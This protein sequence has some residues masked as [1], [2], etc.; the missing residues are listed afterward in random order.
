M[1]GPAQ[2][3][4]GPSANHATQPGTGF[5]GFDRYFSANKPAA[6]QMA[7]RVAGNVENHGQEA[8]QAVQGA[9]DAFAQRTQAA[10]L[11]YDPNRAKSFEE[12]QQLAAT[13]DYSGPK[14]WEDA[15]VDVGNVTS[16]VN[17]AQGQVANLGTV[18]GRSALL[19]ESY[20]SA[21]SSS[22]GSVL[23][24]ALTGQAAGSRFDE[25][26]GLY[27]GVS[28]QM[29]RARGSTTAAHDAARNSSQGAREQYQRDVAG[30]HALD[31]DN[32]AQPL[33]APAPTPTLGDTYTRRN[34]QDYLNAG[35]PRLR[36][37]RG[38]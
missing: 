16:R 12:A 14:S 36:R 29:E 13:P 17:T 34:D 32:R 1:A 4:A 33:P 8:Q 24:A 23:D 22:G 35:D 19:R 7:A 21:P 26:Q 27:G 38:G 37:N 28:Q 20:R 25:L 10:S 6:Q 31:N 15:G 3:A 5:V 9:Q 30:W 11:T 2:P 18:G